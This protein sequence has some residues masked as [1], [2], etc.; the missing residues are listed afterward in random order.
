M[1]DCAV[2]HIECQINPITLNLGRW[3]TILG[4]HGVVCEICW[5]Q[6]SLTERLRFYSEWY[7]THVPQPVDPSRYFTWEQVA[8]A[9][10]RSRL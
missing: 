2:C 3:H 8:A 10:W 1:A 6:M 4:T 7:F 5:D 9:I